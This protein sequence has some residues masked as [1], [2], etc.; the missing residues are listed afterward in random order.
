MPKLQKVG[1]T[2]QQVGHALQQ[3]GHALQQVGHAGARGV[4]GD[5]VTREISVRQDDPERIVLRDG[6]LLVKR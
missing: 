5:A 6:D 3:V 2:L 1:H 4:G